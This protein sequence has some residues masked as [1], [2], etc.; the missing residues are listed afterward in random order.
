MV[1]WK[2]KVGMENIRNTIPRKIKSGPILAIL[3]GISLIKAPSRLSS[4]SVNYFTVLF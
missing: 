4:S 1:P 3:G 2:S